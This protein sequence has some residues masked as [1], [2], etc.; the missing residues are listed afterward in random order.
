MPV[1]VA[2]AAAAA[3]AADGCQCSLNAQHQDLPKPEAPGLVVAK[4]Q[5]DVVML[6]GLVSQMESQKPRNVS[7]R[8]VQQLGV[9]PVKTYTRVFRIRCLCRLWII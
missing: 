5:A 4:E 9:F 8:S 1:V 2:V 3:A 7:K 6:L